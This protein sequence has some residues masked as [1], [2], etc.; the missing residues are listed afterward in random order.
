M[1]SVEIRPSAGEYE[2]GRHFI[3]DRLKE[4]SIPKTMIAETM[5]VYEALYHN[6]TGL[7]D[8]GDTVLKLNV[9]SSFGD[10]RIS[11]GFE[12]PMFDPLDD[13]GDALSPENRILSAY[14]DKIGHSYHSG[15]N[16]ISISVRRSYRQ[17]M[18]SCF[19]AILLGIAAY[20]LLH[21]AAAE[22]YDEFL[23][24]EIVF[25]LETVF[26]HAILMIGAPV[27]FFSL[28]KNLTDI[29]IVSE[30]NSSARKLQI[31]TIVTSFIAVVL[32]LVTGPLIADVLY[33]HEGYFGSLGLFSSGMNM[34]EFIS[35]LVPSNIFEP[36]ETIMPFPIIILSLLLTYALCSIGEYFGAVHRVINISLEV[37]SKMLTVVM[38]TLP[39]FCFFAALSMLIIDGIAN[40]MILLEVLLIVA[41]SMIVISAF[42]MIR[43]LIGKVNIKSFARHL[44]ALLWENFKISSV[45]DAVPFNIRYCSRKYGY[46]RKRLS[47]NLPILAQTNLD[48]NCFLIM[49]ISMSF[50]FLLGIE[51][52]WLQIIGIAFLILFLSVGAPNQPG[53][54]MIGILI[55][56]LYLKAD[57]LILI[58]IF[59]EVFFGW[60]QNIINVLG[61]IVTVAIEEQKY[62]TQIQ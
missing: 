44:P 41:L 48:G 16:R 57:E 28:V 37:F 17:V 9:S 6:L 39:F 7:T 60:L 34:T 54:I 61:D 1:K 59:A 32:A 18:M 8:S 27:T 42:Y 19:I 26:T 2:K 5:L 55:I 29:Y 40:L 56:T 36:F 21:L 62:K 25:P 49:L 43:L 47:D 20:A 4:S 52:S 22:K 31:K 45:I 51:I 38:F 15:Y 24:H 11:I 13:R 12:G 50:I 35:S 30:K 23:L 53:S 58:A 3:L 46:D 10:V 33:T 14:A